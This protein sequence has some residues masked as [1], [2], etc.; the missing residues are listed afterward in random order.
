M[1]RR[2]YHRH[3]TLKTIH[4]RALSDGERSEIPKLHCGPK[5]HN[6]NAIDRPRRAEFQKTTVRRANLN[7]K[8]RAKAT[9]FT[10]LGV[11]RI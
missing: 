10:R 11:L 1:E 4:I 5:F 2:E 7:R 3:N 9:V 6:I 8:E